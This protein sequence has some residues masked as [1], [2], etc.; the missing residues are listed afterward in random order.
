M[1]HV[2]RPPL[3]RDTDRPM[4]AGVCAGIATHLGVRVRWIRLGF[5]LSGLIGIG[6]LSYAMAVVLIDGADGTRAPAS[7]IRL[8]SRTDYF[9]AAVVA[10]GT[11]G[12]ITALAPHLVVVAAVVLLVASLA[13]VVASL[14]PDRSDV[15]RRDIPTWIP[16]AFHDVLRSV[17]GSRALVARTAVGVILAAIGILL[18]LL[19][20]GS[21]SKLVIASSELALVLAGAGLAFGPWISRLAS[22]LLGERRDRI[23]D[24]ERGELAAHLHD[25]VLQTLALVQR[26]A[27]DAGE[28]ARLARVQEREL[29]EW[30][31]HGER[32]TTRHDVFTGAIDA[33]AAELEC[34]NATAIQVVHVR[35]CPMDALL[36]PLV[37]AAREAMSNA[38]RHAGVD[39]ISVY[40]E[41]DPNEIRVFVRDRG[42]GF[43]PAA[44]AADRGGIRE[45]IE[46]RM[47]RHGGAAVIRSELGEGTEIELSMR[48]G[49][50]R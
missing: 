44:V 11:A 39:S 1:S 22:D 34:A 45:S 18:L 21:W 2:M 8:Q 25:S 36:Q 3:L 23:R 30:L 12:L 38:Q 7:R 19:Q 42:R 28:V 9:A 24:R 20:S 33:V 43:D 29:R 27:N 41:V 13:I 4:V 50:S 10:A 48:R 37:D 49:A 17:R 47:R 46:G 40:T 14:A 16:P 31:L 15:D 5:A 35:D 6:V 26:N 32:A